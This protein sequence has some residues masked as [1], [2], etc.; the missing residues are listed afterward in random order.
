MNNHNSLLYVDVIMFALNLI[1]VNV[2]YISK[3]GPLV[4]AMGCDNPVCV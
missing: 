4:R 3:M 1:V 2:I